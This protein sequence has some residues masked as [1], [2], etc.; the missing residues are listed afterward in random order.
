MDNRLSG[1]ARRQMLPAA[2]LSDPLGLLG[3]L[4]ALPLDDVPLDLAQ[5]G[6]VL[7]PVKVLDDRVGMVVVVQRLARRE[8]EPTAAGASDAGFRVFDYPWD[9][10]IVAIHFWLET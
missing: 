2:S 5:D 9:V 1:G 4:L 3:R 10:T 7:A 8:I 6:A